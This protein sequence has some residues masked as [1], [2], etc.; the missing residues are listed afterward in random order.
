MNINTVIPEGYKLV[1]INKEAH[2]KAMKKYY[3]ANRE[4]IKLQMLTN[5]KLKYHSDEDFKLKEQTRML[6][7][8]KLKKINT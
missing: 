2:Q 1:R 6:N 5:Y 4:K 8:S 7:N 3:L